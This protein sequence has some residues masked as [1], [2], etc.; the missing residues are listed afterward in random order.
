M[1]HH[2]PH[3]PSAQANDRLA[4]HITA[5]HHEQGWNLLCN[6]VV[7][8]DDNGALLPNGCV[9]APGQVQLGFGPRTG[10]QPQ[11]VG[12]STQQVPDFAPPD[13]GRPVRAGALSGR[14]GNH[15]AEGLTRN[16]SSVGSHTSMA[17]RKAD[18]DRRCQTGIGGS[19]D[20]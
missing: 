15:C 14:A 8:F 11:L 5:A 3:C 6:G 9:I 20:G 2:R 4:A 7:V 1:C 18:A 19:G 13:R 12:L 10:L 16:G 17:W